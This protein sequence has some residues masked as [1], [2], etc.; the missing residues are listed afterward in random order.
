MSNRREGKG[1]RVS[2]ISLPGVTGVTGKV[3][4]GSAKGGVRVRG[5]TG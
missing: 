5:K 3:D 2:G 1:D 4:P